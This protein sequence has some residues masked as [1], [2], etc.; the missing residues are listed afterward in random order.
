MLGLKLRSHFEGVS[1]LWMPVLLGALS[2]LRIGGVASFVVPA[3]LFTGISA[4]TVREWTLDQMEDIRID[5]FPPGKFPDVL[6]EVVVL[7]ARRADGARASQIRVSQHQKGAPPREWNATVAKTRATWTSVF[8]DPEE[9]RALAE[10]SALAAVVKL[11]DVARLQVS[12]VTGANDYFCA[13]DEEIDDFQLA[14]WVLPLLPRIRHATGLVWRERDQVDLSASTKRWLVHFAEN[15]KAP[16]LYE[17]A[18]RFLAAGV[19]RGIPV[20]YKCRV[21]SPWYRV[22]DVHHGSLMLSKR[23]HRF[24]KLVLNKAQT[25]TT[26]TIYRGEMKTGNSGRESDLVASFHNS[27]TLL[28]VELEGRSFGGGVLEI[29]PSEIARLLVPLPVSFGKHLSRLDR[30]C[31]NASTSEPDELIT[32]TD[33]LLVHADF[34]LTW[35][36]VGTLADARRKLMERRLSRV[37]SELDAPRSEL[38]AV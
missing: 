14:R 9:H 25:F 26:D 29:V 32:E 20:R 31:R 18:A 3:E 28:T 10:A 12:I 23:S 7:S 27:L 16:E 30:T 36:I 4:R 35:R 2:K 21:R 19:A 24:P 5:L 37:R 15:Q 33:R 34:G 1:N 13:S 22:P 6:Q 8:L 11:G 38:V 17:G